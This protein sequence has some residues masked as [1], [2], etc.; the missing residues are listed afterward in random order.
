MSQSSEYKVLI[1]DPDHTSASGIEAILEDEGYLVTVEASY[2][3]GVSALEASESSPYAVVIS[4][5]STDKM[6]GS[7]ILKQAKRIVP[8]TRRMLMV[9]PAEIGGVIR[10]VNEAEIHCCL[11]VPIENTVLKEKIEYYC[12]QFNRN[13]ETNR[14]RKVTR[15]Q[16]RQMY[17][18]AQ[19]FKKKDDLFANRIKKRKKKLRILASQK[20][21]TRIGEKKE[22]L[23]LDELIEKKSIP[24]SSEK[25]TNVFLSLAD[26]L[27]KIFKQSLSS[28]SIELEAMDFEKAAEEKASTLGDEAAQTSDDLENE[29]G[30][31]KDKE[32]AGEEDAS[33]SGG[34]QAEGAKGKTEEK[35]DGTEPDEGQLELIDQVLNLL[36]TDAG[37]TIPENQTADES[38]KDGLEEGDADPEEETLE[39]CIE[40]SFTEDNLRAMVTMKKYNSSL[41]TLDSLLE[42]LAANDI[43]FGIKDDGLISAWLSSEK[44]SKK[45]LVIAEGTPPQPSKDAKVKYLF[46]TDFR[47]AGKVMSDGSIDFRDRGDIPFVR[48]DT[49]LCEKVLAVEGVEGTDVSGR[50]IPVA[51]PEDLVF[52]CGSGTRMS[53]DKRR[54]FA[55]S[56]GQPSLDTM[57]KV[58]VFAELS[59]KGDVDYNTGNISFDGNIVVAGT[60]KEGFSIQGA[61]LTAGQIEG[62]KIDLTGD[63]N[64][65]SGIIDA[66]LIDVQ[67]TVQ[68]KYVN[69][70]AI[71]AFGDLIVQKEIIDSEIFLTGACINETGT[72]ISSVIVAK[73]GMQLGQVG[74]DVSLPAKLKVGVDEHIEKQIAAVDENLQDNSE[75]LE[76]LKQEMSKLESEDQELNIKISDHAYVQDRSQIEIRDVQKMLTALKTS[77]NIKEV[78]NT[79]EKIK[80]LNEK[81]ELAEKDINKAFERQDK[82]VAEI[83]TKKEKIKTI[84]ESNK[85]LVKKKKA[86]R[87]YSKKSGLLSEL[88]VNKKIL[89]GTL[90]EAPNAVIKIKETTSKCK[91]IE[92]RHTDED[93]G[94]SYYEMEISNF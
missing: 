38:G 31:E 75:A 27:E 41:L 18:L 26:D 70:S 8:E 9:D 37:S 21:D 10:A 3:K 34:D 83:D 52:D 54:I 88:S 32:D 78:N 55:D 11:P 74:T 64:V 68:A 45:A 47:Q 79:T 71:K 87:E 6:D 93:G 92:I 43:G 77:G 13:Q 42:Y 65:A 61:T 76:G 22:T 14:L 28:H 82:I 80:K 1:I 73:M 53:E 23:S 85:T 56:D 84:E 30:N 50:P 94:A 2:Q 86:I 29:P 57:G 17:I 25:Y 12:S 66:K 33:V 48:K 46:E 90:I 67:G 40:I 81:V 59:I 19:Q 16:N 69:N 36:Y 5:L 24:P 49:L 91:I 51:K 63:L 39:S 44:I 4:G 89:P 62:A 20:R 35:E 58:S 15:R 7:R 60:V 72:V